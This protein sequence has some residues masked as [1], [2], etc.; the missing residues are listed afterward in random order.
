[1]KEEGEIDRKSET[2]PL[3]IRQLEMSEEPD[4]PGDQ[5][6]TAAGHVLKS[7]SAR[8]TGTNYPGV[9]HFQQMAMMGC[10]PNGAKLTMLFSGRRA[11]KTPQSC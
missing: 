7:E 6:E 10:K 9:R 8:I 4:F 5:L 2:I 3:R 1:M 11:A